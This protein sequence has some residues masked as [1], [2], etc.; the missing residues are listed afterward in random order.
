[1]KI[2]LAKMEIHEKSE[3]ILSGSMESFEMEDAKEVRAGKTKK[4][5]PIY[6]LAIEEHPKLDRFIWVLGRLMTIGLYVGCVFQLISL[7]Q[8]YISANL[9]FSEMWGILPARESVWYENSSVLYEPFPSVTICAPESARENLVLNTSI[10]PQIIN[11]LAT[12]SNQNG[13]F[14]NPQVSL[15]DFTAGQANPNYLNDWIL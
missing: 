15:F 9:S 5:K 4:L 12:G 13:I 3:S 7:V 2:T 6:H 14:F 10:T 11:Q 1:M 8:R